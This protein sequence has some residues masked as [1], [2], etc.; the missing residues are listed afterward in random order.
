MSTMRS[1]IRISA[2]SC[3]LRLL[4]GLVC[5]GL[6][7]CV[8]G[9][10]GGTIPYNVQ[11]FREPDAPSKTAL[12]S[13][14]RI[15]PLDKLTI[16]VF[17]VEDLSGE[18]QVGLLGNVAMPLIGNVRAVDLTPS[19]LQ[20]ELEG[21]LAQTYL[22]SPKVAVAI[23]EATG[24]MLTVEGAVRNPGVFPA[25]GNT[26]LIQ[27]IALAKGLDDTANPKRVAI[28]RQV[29]GQRMAAAFDLATIR[30][31]I[32]PD[33][34][35]YRGDI[36]VVEGSNTRKSFLDIVRAVPIFGV[37]APMTYAGN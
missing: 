2:R 26:T 6:S 18:Y 5:F 7:A 3:R 27:A 24:S 33:P 30:G 29:D 32:D 4:L 14:Y 36:I 28:F 23:L 11:D 13:N 1:S 12:I 16:N 34:P 22:K 25:Y 19:E 17:R 15:G 9:S 10:R 37:F 8:G 35:V 20:A 31:G 21:K